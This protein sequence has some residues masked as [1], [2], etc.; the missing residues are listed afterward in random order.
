MNTPRVNHSQIARPAGVSRST[1]SRALKNHPALPKATREKIQTLA[2]EMGYRPN[3][4]VSALMAARNQSQGTTGASTLAVLSA[5][6]PLNEPV[7]HVTQR[8]LFNGIKQRSED[9]GFTLEEFWVDQPGL[10]LDR[11]DQILQSRGIVAV[12]FAPIPR[13]HPPLE[14]SWDAYSLAS[15]APYDQIPCFH[16]ASPFHFQSACLATRRLLA[17]GY[18]RPGIVISSDNAPHLRDQW[19]GGYLAA[20]QEEAPTRLIPPLVIPQDDGMTRVAQWC[21]KH[22]PDVVLGNDMRLPEWLRGLRSKRQRPIAFA[23]LDRQPQQTQEA[24]ID[25]VHEQVGAAVVDLIAAQIN[26]NERGIPSSPSVVHLT[27]EWIDGASAPPV[28]SS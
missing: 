1:V 26:R 15:F 19:V 18:R 24:G 21:R 22:R 4:L 27:G 3:P 9:L 14:L 12:L 2:R 17:L 7:L 20:T 25:Q 10:S 11:L 6:H 28:T 5:W 13:H 8:R 23:N 16:Q